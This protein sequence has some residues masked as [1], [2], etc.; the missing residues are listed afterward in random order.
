M[1]REVGHRGVD[2]HHL[3]GDVGEREVGDHAEGTVDEVGV[4]RDVSA[5]DPGDVIVRDHNRLGVAGGAGGVDEGGAVAGLLVSHARLDLGVGDGGTEGDEIV[6]AVH[7]G[8]AVADAV[9]D[10]GRNL[11]APDDD[12]R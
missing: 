2:V 5:G 1:V 12:W 4:V 11:V 8:L 10:V 6:P 3:R 9:V 7:L